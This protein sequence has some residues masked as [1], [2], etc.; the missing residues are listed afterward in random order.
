MDSISEEKLSEVHPELA[1]RVRILGDKC[2][3][4]D[5]WLRVSQGLRTWDQQDL[6]YAQGRTDGGKI[7]TNAKGGYSMHNFGLAVDIV[8]GNASF[9]KFTPDWEG[10]DYRW[11]QVLLLGKTCK[12][13][14]GAEWRTYPDRPHLYPEEIPATPDDNYRY[15]FREGGLRAVWDEVNLEEAA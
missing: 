6:L 8:P 9:P 1:R 15:L 5:I 12:L 4:N 2:A 3:A 11:Q 13:A 7:V 10:M 14:E